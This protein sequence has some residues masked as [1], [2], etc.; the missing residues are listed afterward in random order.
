M[1]EP[2]VNPKAGDACGRNTWSDY[3]TPDNS[4][5]I[6][7]NQ[8]YGTN[9]EPAVVF[10]ATYIYSP[11]AKNVEFQIGSDDTALIW[12]NNVNVPFNQANNG[13]E[14][15]ITNKITL[16]LN[17]G[18]NTLLIRIVNNGGAWM[19]HTRIDVG[20]VKTSLNHNEN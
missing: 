8:E 3:S 19:L 4:G 1:G 6:D 14:T 10:A 2:A 5:S 7:F 16:N 12:L 18:W 20:G 15:G 17:P 9:G 11:E 13:G